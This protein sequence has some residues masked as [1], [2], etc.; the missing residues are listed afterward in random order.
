MVGAPTNTPFSNSPFVLTF[1]LFLYF[2]MAFFRNSIFFTVLLATAAAVELEADQEA[3]RR[4]GDRVT[5]LPGQ[6]PVNF[7]HYAGYVKLRPDQPQEQKALFYWF[8]EAHE[9]KDVGSKPLV[10]WL[11]GGSFFFS[12][13]PKFIHF[14]E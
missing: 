11:N 3:R 12:L 13:F 9:A 2:P 1:S 7:S 10:L 14:Y 4:E 5:G 6:P 8:F